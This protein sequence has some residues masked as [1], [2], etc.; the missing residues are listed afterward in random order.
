M[1]GSARIHLELSGGDGRRMA[2]V[3][4]LFDA[5]N[6][7]RLDEKLETLAP[8]IDLPLSEAI[9]HAAEHSLDQKG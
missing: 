1:A 8:Q 5:F 7:G 4:D 9:L 3:A 6:Q 2:W